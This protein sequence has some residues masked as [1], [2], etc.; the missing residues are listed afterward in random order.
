MWRR[1]RAKAFSLTLTLGGCAGC[2]VPLEGGRG[3][4]AVGQ[5]SWMLSASSW[6]GEQG[7][8]L[9]HVVPRAPRA[10]GCRRDSHTGLS[11]GHHRLPGGKEDPPGQ[12]RPAAGE[13]Q[14]RRLYL[15]T[16]SIPHCVP[17]SWGWGPKPT[18]LMGTP[19]QPLALLQAADLVIRILYLPCSSLPSYWL[20]RGAGQWL[21]PHPA[22]IPP[23]SPCLRC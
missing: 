3:A 6:H 11:R 19:P 9:G 8:L 22:P 20:R 2:L 1:D 4:A 14:V 16:C 13:I 7:G 15:G 23:I 17:L 5:G 18:A 12:E 21:L 10:Q